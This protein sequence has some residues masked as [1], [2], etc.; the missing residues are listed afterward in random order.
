MRDAAAEERTGTVRGVVSGHLQDLG[1][2]RCVSWSRGRRT[3][4][5]TRVCVNVLSVGRLLVTQ[6]LICG[7]RL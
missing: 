7:K 4:S 3:M 6:G 1:P 5:K 2:V